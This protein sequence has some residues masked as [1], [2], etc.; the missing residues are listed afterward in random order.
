MLRADTG[1]RALI[2]R[3]NSGE[4]NFSRRDVKEEGGGS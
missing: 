3:Y 1:G 2:V 4:R